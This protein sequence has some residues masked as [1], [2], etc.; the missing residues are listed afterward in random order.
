[1]TSQVI[2]KNISKSFDGKMVLS[3]LNLSLPYGTITC[4]MGESGCGK[5]TLLRI[6]LGLERADSGE[7]QGLPARLVC[8]FQ[9]DRLLEGFSVRTNIRIAAK[10]LTNAEIDAHLAELGLTGEGDARI[11]ALSGGMKRRVALIRAIC[12]P[13]DMLLLDEP[14]KGLDEHSAAQAAEYLLRHQNGR[15]V[16]LVTHEKDDALRLHAPIFTL[17]RD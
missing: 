17:Q 7:I 4:L 13:S 9:K 2:I 14:F 6:L 16:L 10:S 11:S 5:T 15:T 3:D 8:L 12:A 1:M